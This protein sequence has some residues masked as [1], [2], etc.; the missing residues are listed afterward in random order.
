MRVGVGLGP[1]V[2]AMEACAGIARVGTAARPA[3]AATRRARARMNGGGQFATGAGGSRAQGFG[4]D[5]LVWGPRH[6]QGRA[7]GGRR[8]GRQWEDRYD[9]FYS[10]SNPFPEELVAG[11][12]TGAGHAA[13]STWSAARVRLVGTFIGPY[14]RTRGEDIGGLDP[15]R[16]AVYTPPPFT[17]GKLL[18]PSMGLM[19]GVAHSY[20]VGHE[21]IY[22]DAGRELRA[23]ADCG[24][25]A[26]R[27]AP[28]PNGVMS[29]VMTVGSKE[30]YPK[31]IDVVNFHATAWDRES[32][33]MLGTTTRGNG[34]PQLRPL[35]SIDGGL[36][37]VLEAM[38]PGERRRAWVEDRCYDLHMLDCLECWTPET[39]ADVGN[40]PASATSVE[41][42]ADDGSGATASLHY[43]TL[44]AGAPGGDTPDVFDEVRVH[45]SC[46]TADGE[47]VE[48]TGWHGMPAELPVGAVVPGL[49]AALQQM[50]V[51]E[52]VRVWLPSELAYG[53]VDLPENDVP[54]GPLTFEVE[55]LG[56]QR[57]TKTGIRLPTVVEPNTGPSAIQKMF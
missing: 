42:V 56:I 3:A 37:G 25:P 9:E 39:P 34:T 26:P 47:L 17:G 38:S 8:G 57:E 44:S 51:G 29:K 50:S 22:F 40:A 54:T 46:W 6:E 41:L 48:T 11:P 21:H 43:I 16:E 23:P 30:R 31:D 10:E 35:D 12:T 33:I 24:T 27:A 4:R 28:L 2:G 32:G 36:R 14:H 45:Y 53:D 13:L 52:S 20:P 1:S 49:S 7:G 5:E 55:L 18:D 15:Q 19:P